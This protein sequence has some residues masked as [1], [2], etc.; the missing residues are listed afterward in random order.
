MNDNEALFSPESRGRGEHGQSYGLERSTYARMAWTAVRVSDANAAEP[1]TITGLGEGRSGCL[2]TLY[3]NRH[4]A[5]QI[6]VDADHEMPMISLSLL[7]LDARTESWAQIF[8][9]KD[10]REDWDHIAELIIERESIGAV[11]I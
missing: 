1:V 9:A 3:G 4:N 7:P 2:L 8:E 5:Y 11:D 10:Y 6:K